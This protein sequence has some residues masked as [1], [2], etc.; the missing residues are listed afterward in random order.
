[1]HCGEEL[2]MS[3]CRCKRSGQVLAWVLL[4]VHLSYTWVLIIRCNAAVQTA[5]QHP[6]HVQIGKICFRDATGPVAS[7]GDTALNKS[8]VYDW[9][10]WFKNRQESENDQRSGRPSTSKTKEM[11]EKVRQLIW[12]DRKMIIAELEQE[13]GISH[14]PFR[15]FCPMI[16]RWDIRKPRI[17]KMHR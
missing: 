16:W 10:S 6:V 2:S 11:I 12:S 17:S 1:M 5:C 4:V 7:Y 3:A 13:V 8:A 15:R 9:F 14:H